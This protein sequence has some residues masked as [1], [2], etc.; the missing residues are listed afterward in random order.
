MNNTMPKHS[1]RLPLMKTLTVGILVGLLSACTL[2]PNYR[3][4]DIPISEQFRNAPA[5]H[6]IADSA[7]WQAFEQPS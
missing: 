3:R 7:W 1:S 4:P 2:G 6:T 5:V